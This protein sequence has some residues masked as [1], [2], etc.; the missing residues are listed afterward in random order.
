[1]PAYL[2]K[3][4]ILAV[5]AIRFRSLLLRSDIRNPVLNHLIPCRYCAQPGENGHHLIECLELPVAFIKRRESILLRIA[6]EANLPFNNTR[7]CQKHLRELMFNLHWPKQT[8]GLLHDTMAFMKD[9]I[10]NYAAYT[11]PR[12]PSYLRMIPVAPLRPSWLPYL[13]RV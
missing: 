8:E 13:R 12:E 9:L 5:A 3:G 7:H 11:S 10:I 2:K 4:G 1:M 6:E